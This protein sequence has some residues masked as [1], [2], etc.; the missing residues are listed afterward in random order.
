MRQEVFVMDRVRRKFTAEQKA[1]AVAEIRRTGS[2]TR[3]AINLGI[4][5]KTLRRWVKEMKDERE[6]GEKESPGS[7]S[8]SEVVELK[9]RLKRLEMEN[10]FLKK[11]AA[12][13]AS[14]ATREPTS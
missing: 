4:D 2:I 12:F 1:S 5:R 10:A 11:A 9:R 8:A 14:D 6:S 13:F 3:A 7:E